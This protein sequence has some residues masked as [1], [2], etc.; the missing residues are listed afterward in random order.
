[1]AGRSKV[2]GYGLPLVGVAALLGGARTVMS[3]QPQRPVETP[4]V[5]PP[6]SPSAAGVSS[7]AAFIG[8]TGAVE[9]AGRNI[10]IGA[11][12]SGVVASMGAGVGEAVRAGQVLF[13]IDARSAEAEVAQRRA[14][15]AQAEARVAELRATIPA[16]RAR[17]EASAA[18]IISAEAATAR[19]RGDLSRAQAEL[20]DR[21]NQL[22]TGELAATL[23]ARA[24]AGEILEARR[25]AVRAAE[26]NIAA[27]EAWVAQNEAGIASARAALAGAQADLA[28]LVEP[29][30]GADGAQ[31]RSALSAVEQARA[32]L[33]AAQTDLELRTVRSPIDGVVLQVDT[34]AGE[35][36]LAGVNATPLMVVGAIERLHVRA[37]LDEV[38]IPRFRAGA[39]AWAT[40]RG[41][42]GSR[43]ALS[44]VRVEPLVIP[45]RQLSGATSERVDTR[46]LE[47]V[48]ALPP[49]AEGLYVGQQVDVYVEAS[50]V[51]S[52]S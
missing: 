31:V 6:I 7:S 1:M 38:D 35:F 37:Q 27:A 23:D 3:D 45:K 50:S 17:V 36:A 43:L 20:S 24:I 33:L 42:A 34:R 9:A 39:A 2:L 19:A 15:L 14:D 21:Q 26:A 32:G 28:V 13:V 29:E 48:F 46:V 8:A 4:L 40:P 22:R 41:D 52:G 49:G 51:G 30:T 16:A 10:R 5:M 25:F 44:L 12:V 18:Q 11:H 47:V